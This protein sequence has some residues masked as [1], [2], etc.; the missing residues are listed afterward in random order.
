MDSNGHTFVFCIFI[1]VFSIEQETMAA[2]VK[3]DVSVGPTK[4][5]VAWSSF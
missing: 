5:T 3:N 4:R 1:H 2:V